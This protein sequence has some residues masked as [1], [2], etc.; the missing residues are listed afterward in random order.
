MQKKSHRV[1]RYVGPETE[2]RTQLMSR[3]EI[4]NRF[5]SE[6]ASL[7]SQRDPIWLPDFRYLLG[8]VPRLLEPYVRDGGVVLDL[9]AG[10]GNLSRGIL[11]ALPACRA[12]LVD[13]SENMLAEVPRVL[14]PYEG[15]YKTVLGDFMDMDLGAG[16][17]SGAAA[18]FSLHHCRSEAEYTLVYRRIHRSLRCPS[19]FVCCD[20]VQ[21]AD[22]M[23]SDLNEKEWK[24][25]LEAQGLSQEEIAR[26]LSNYH[27]ED[28]PLCVAG[29]LRLL[30]EAGFSHAD[31]V[32][33]RANFA[34]YVGIKTRPDA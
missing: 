5:D 2:S 26:I 11:E 18:S 7:Y 13:F 4:K 15:R 9:G 23:L 8:L 25:F 17:Y 3:E 20:V 14:R 28:T 27:V 33:K 6:V 34:V 31:V 16:V 24:E 30:H 29:H 32:C 10:T 22:T 19:V 21:G 1:P 12:V